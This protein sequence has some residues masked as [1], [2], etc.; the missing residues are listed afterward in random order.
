[1]KT[2]KNEAAIRKNLDNALHAQARTLRTGTPEAYEAI[3]ARVA[4]ILD[5]L[6][7]SYGYAR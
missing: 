7:E 5:V 1:M 2:P 3:T 6:R 4:S